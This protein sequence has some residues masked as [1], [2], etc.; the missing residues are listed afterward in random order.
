MPG[1]REGF[2]SAIYFDFFSSKLHCRVD[3]TAIEVYRN[4]SSYW[5]E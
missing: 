5:V 4:R 3:A 2:R 1:L